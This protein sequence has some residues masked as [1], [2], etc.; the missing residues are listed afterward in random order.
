MEET[1][2]AQA[3]SVHPDQRMARVR[4]GGFA[5]SQKPLRHV[6]LVSSPDV[7][8]L[9]SVIVLDLADEDEAI[10][11][12]QKLARETGRRVT[13]RDETLVLI[14]TIPAASVH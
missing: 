7:S 12:A 9:G 3:S 14:K 4:R 11:M 13:V 2:H 8:K 1:A 5:M 6:I 10:K